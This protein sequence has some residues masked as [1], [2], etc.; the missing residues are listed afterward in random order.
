MAINTFLNAN[1][2][3]KVGIGTETPAGK[4]DVNGSVYLREATY[5]QIHH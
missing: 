3:G 2:T 5:L 1:N 4:L